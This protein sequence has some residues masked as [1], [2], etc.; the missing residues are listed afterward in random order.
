MCG[1]VDAC[2]KMIDPYEEMQQAAEKANTDLLEKICC[3]CMVVLFMLFGMWI[4]AR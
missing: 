4:D 3:F 1:D 2:F